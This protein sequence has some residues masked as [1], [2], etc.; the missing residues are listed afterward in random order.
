MDEMILHYC[1]KN[2]LFNDKPLRT[3]EGK[4]ITLIHTGYSHHDAGPDFVQAK[5]I[6]DNITW[7]GDVEIHVRTSDWLRHGHQHDEKYQSI[8]LHVVYEDDLLL[9]GSFHTLELKSYIPTAWLSECEQMLCSEADFP[10]HSVLQRM[11]SLQFSE[12]FA[13]MAIERLSARERDIQEMQRQCSGDW[14]EVAYR[15]LLRNFGFKVNGAAFEA[16]ARS[17]PYAIL[18]K[19]ALSRLQIYAL[20][21][22]QAGFLSHIADDAYYMS[23]HREYKFLQF[24][25]QLNPIA[26]KVWNL[27][28]RP[29]NA[30]CL[31]LAQ[32]CE[33][34]I[35]IPS[36]TQQ[37]L[38]Q[39]PLQLLT[40]FMNH[41]P[42]KYWST[43][44]YFDKPTQWHACRMGKSTIVSL[45]VNTIIPLQYAYA[46]FMSDVALKERA[47]RALEALPQERNFITRK[48][49]QAGFP[50]E[51][52]LSTQAVIELH[53]AYCLHNRC[54]AC[55]V[56]C[57]FLRTKK[58]TPNVPV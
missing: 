22:G 6:I 47:V 32:L 17:L 16:I 9:G 20:L 49:K 44:Y 13:R 26:L 19:H 8:I 1:W 43:H 15:L 51:S 39:P 57:S 38:H 21:F 2:R 12:L 29:Q 41:T 33:C 56:G 4:P 37:I 7:V 55:E 52:A 5:I 42:D 27:R 35:R 28:T 36:I 10:C 53:N 30:P 25:Y 40:T 48:Y 58:G 14:N 3:T 24:K 46:T 54:L 23:L 50:I 11:T 31:R 34:L 18:L 45:M